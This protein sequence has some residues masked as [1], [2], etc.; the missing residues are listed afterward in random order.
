MARTVGWLTAEYPLL[1]TLDEGDSGS[2][3]DALRA[4]KSVLRAVPDRGVGYGQLRYLDA[5]RSTQLQPL[6]QQHAPEVLF[7]YLG[8]FSAGDGLWTPQRT[9]KHFRDAFAVHQSPDMPQLHSLEINIF[10]DETGAL[11][12]LAVNWGW[13]NGVFSEQDIDAL[14]L[15]LAGACDALSDFARRH[16]QEAA[17]TL[18]A[19]EVAIDGVSQQDR[20]G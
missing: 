18:V 15:A 11:P 20:A 7:N 4:V 13:L 8:R 3:R 19:A 16:P 17:D 5:V 9:R 12:Q 14:H 6:A 2:L 10:V 1:V